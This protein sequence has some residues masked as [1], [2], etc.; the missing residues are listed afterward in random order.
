MQSALK[1]HYDTK[2]VGL[3]GVF[4]LTCGK[5]RVHVMVWTITPFI[6]LICSICCLNNC[7]LLPRDAMQARSMPSCGLC[8]SHSCIVSKRL[9]IQSVAMECEQETIPRLSNGTKLNDREWLRTK[10]SRKRH[11]LTLNISENVRDS[12]LTM[13]SGLTHALRKGVILN[14]LEWPWVILRNIQWHEAA[15]GLSAT[16]YIF[17]I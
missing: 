5:A 2:S 14:D 4:V 13:E 1:R 6:A 11:Y 8:L 17:R 16:L 9:Q 3:G 12:Q 7:W 10:I 15:R